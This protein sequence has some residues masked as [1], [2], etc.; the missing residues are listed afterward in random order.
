MLYQ[1]LKDANIV[2]LKSKDSTAR[3]ILS[4]VLNKVKN[5]EINV[6]RASGKDLTDSD[7]I[8]I[9]TKTAKELVEEKQAFESANRMEQVEQL[10]AQIAFLN[11]FLPK[12]MSVEEISQIINSLD[13]K[14]MPAVMKHFK[15][16]YSGKCNMADVQQ[17]FKNM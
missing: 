14:S 12:M 17:A 2:A 1:Q 11:G 6:L 16:N 9:L 4:L 10:D 7:V 5:H 3:S 13:D 15:M 8:N